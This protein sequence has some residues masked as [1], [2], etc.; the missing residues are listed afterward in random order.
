MV[1]PPGVITAN[2]LVSLRIFVDTSLKL[3][4]VVTTGAG[5]GQDGRGWAGVC[6]AGPCVTALP[7]LLVCLFFPR[8]SLR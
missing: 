4:S 6:L 5:R 8:V 2:S 7:R 3:A 1:V